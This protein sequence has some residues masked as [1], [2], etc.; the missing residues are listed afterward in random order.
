VN[1][2]LL[3]ASLLAA[4]VQTAFALD[5]HELD[6]R[7]DA[8]AEQGGV[9]NNRALLI[10]R[11]DAY[12]EAGLFSEAHRDYEL[13][14]HLGPSRKERLEILGRLAVCA[15]KGSACDRAI[16]YYETALE[17]D[18]KQWGARLALA[19]DYARVDLNGKSLESYDLY[20]KQFPQS[21]EAQFERGRLLQKMGF[22]DRAIEAYQGALKITS[23]F[24]VITSISD[25]YA[26][27][28][29]F[30]KAIQTLRDAEKDL[31][32]EE[33]ESRLAMLYY[34]TGQLEEAVRHWEAALKTDPAREVDAL[35]LMTACMRMKAYGRAEKIGL[36]WTK[37]SPDR[38]LFHFLLGWVYLRE[39][40]KELAVQSARLAESRAQSEALQNW[41]HHLA[42]LTR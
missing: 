37:A 17:L 5:P 15:E 41:S 21:F 16:T 40:K 33:F 42:E 2:S 11:A 6:R 24:D 3:S 29:N 28:G 23:R 12:F 25:S 4:L 22:L 31:P 35:Y 10:Q 20:L 30:E 1:R 19:R 13:A 27:Q 9:H 18:R 39:G 38:G 26:R 32:Q 34:R 8:A 7:I 14:L 36:S